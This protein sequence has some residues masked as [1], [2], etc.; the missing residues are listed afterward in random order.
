[1]S[2]TTDTR[3]AICIVQNADDALLLVKRSAHRDFNPNLWGFPGGHIEDNESPQETAWRELREEIGE[4]HQVELQRCAGPFRDRH[5]GGRI[6]AHL[7][8][9]RW[10][11]GTITLD[12]EHTDYAWAD[13]LRLHDYELMPGIHADLEHLD[14]RTA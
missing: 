10:L 11:G 8:L 3:Y 12:A 13:P 9:Y 14:L 5:Y 6:E 2:P 7:F 1:M 4:N